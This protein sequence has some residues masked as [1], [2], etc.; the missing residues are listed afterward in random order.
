MGF[1]EEDFQNIIDNNYKVNN[2]YNFFTRDNLIKMAGNSI[3]VN[4]LELVFRQ[5]LDIKK[6][7]FL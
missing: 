2:K 6:K 1:D 3:P 4:V 5:I 7:F